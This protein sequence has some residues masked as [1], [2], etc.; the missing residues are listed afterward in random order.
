MYLVFTYF[1]FSLLLKLIYTGCF[2]CCET[3]SQD[4]KI[5]QYSRPVSRWLYQGSGQE[6]HCCRRRGDHRAQYVRPQTLDLKPSADWSPA[7]PSIPGHTG[8]W[9]S[10][11]TG[12]EGFWLLRYSRVMKDGGDSVGHRGHPLHPGQGAAQQSHLTALLDSRYE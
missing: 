4:Y 5:L 10:Q 12:I 6:H 7:H 8:S 9:Y 1:A 2:I 3:T 11:Q